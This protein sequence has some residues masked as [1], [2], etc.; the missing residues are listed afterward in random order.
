LNSDEFRSLL[1]G[2]T[3][4][5]ATSQN[6]IVYKAL[7]HARMVKAN[8]ITPAS[9]MRNQSGTAEDRLDEPRPKP[10]VSPGQISCFNRDSPLEFSLDEFERHIDW[11]QG[12]KFNASKNKFVPLVPSDDLFPRIASVRSKLNV[13]KLDDRLSFLMRPQPG[14]KLSD[15]VSQFTGVGQNRIKIIDLSGTPSEIAGVLSACLARLLFQYK[16][17]QTDEERKLDPVLLVCEEAHRYVPNSGEAEYRDAQQSIR[18]IAKEGRKYGLA[19]MLVS[20]RP[21]DL[22][23]TVLS[24][25]GSWIVM[26]LTNGSDQEHV[27]RFLPDNLTGMTRLLPSLG[28]REAL[29]VGE[30]AAIPSRIF[31]RELT[32]DQRPSSNDMDFVSGW[33]HAGVSKEQIVKVTDRWQSLPIQQ[34][35]STGHASPPSGTA[36]QNITAT[37]EDE[38]AF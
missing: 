4:H 33:S 20:Q 35:A 29:F 22:E 34:T 19:L 12:V 38:P 14:D 36:T 37:T 31:M 3:E 24:Q 9:D 21:S 10:G 15:I 28:R 25:C 23:S 30:A 16:V 11:N 32:D 5:E 2:K 13:L 1:I 27:G 18:R 6:N 7:T 17:W 8:L 26:R